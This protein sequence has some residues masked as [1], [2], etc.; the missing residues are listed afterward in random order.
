MSV[1]DG[2]LNLVEK[3]VGL[4]LFFVMK[5]KGDDRVIK[6]VNLADEDKEENTTDELLKK[7]TDFLRWRFQKPEEFHITNLSSAD[8]R[9]NAV[10]KYDLVEL[11]EIFNKMQDTLSLMSKECPTFDHRKDDFSNITG[12]IIIIGNAEQNVVLFKENYPISLLKRDRFSLAPVKHKTRLE[13]VKKDIFKLDINFHFI[14]FNGAFYIFD[15]NK[16]EK[17]TGFDGIIKNEAL[18]SIETIKENGLVQDTQPL[19]DEIENITF[20]RKLT[21]IYRE[22]KVIGKIPNDKIIQFVDKHDYF[23]KNPIK[24]TPEKDQ[25]IIDTKVSKKALVKLLNDDLLYSE[26]TEFQYESLAKNNVYT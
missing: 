11:P 7:Y 10:Y 19:R 23:K 3:N 6:F 8:D 2:I 1:F 15:L 25:L 17:L 20:S 18:K 21:K 13:K 22:S 26:L 16:L 4:T 9:K 24:I 12:I 14:L 5:S